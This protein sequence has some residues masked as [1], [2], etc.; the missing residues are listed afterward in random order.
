MA[1]ELL[2]CR[3]KQPVDLQGVGREETCACAD[4]VRA[5]LRELANLGVDGD[6]F[7]VGEAAAHLAS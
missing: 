2:L 7:H 4:D 5:A 3:M 6:I 1:I